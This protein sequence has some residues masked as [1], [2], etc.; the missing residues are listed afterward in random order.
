MMNLTAFTLGEARELL[1]DAKPFALKYARAERFITHQARFYTIQAKGLTVSVQFNE[2]KASDD[3]AALK[4]I[5][6][7]LL[8]P[9]EPLDTKI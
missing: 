8:A 9:P 2:G 1:L 7:D 3:P 5:L 6:L 4:Q